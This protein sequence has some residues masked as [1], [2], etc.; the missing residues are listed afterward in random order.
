MQRFAIDLLFSRITKF[1][2]NENEQEIK[3]RSNN[4]DGS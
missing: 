2:S 1:L 3:L 4:E